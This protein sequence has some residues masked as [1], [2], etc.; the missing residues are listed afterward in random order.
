MS[1]SMYTEC[2]CGTG[3]GAL[4]ALFL[5]PLLCCLDW[6]SFCWLPALLLC[7][8]EP[9]AGG[10]CSSSPGWLPGMAEEASRICRRIWG[11]P[12]CGL[13]G[14]DEA[15]THDSVHHGGHLVMVG[16]RPFTLAQRTGL[17]ILRSC[18]WQGESFLQTSWQGH[19]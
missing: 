16:W 19:I 8:E 17:W 10:N 1:Q 15:M 3:K 12:R 9:A 18:W 11:W 5:W 7:C 14:E 13:E 4:A 2:S 6:L